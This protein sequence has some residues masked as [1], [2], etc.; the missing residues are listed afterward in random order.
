M[1]KGIRRT[2]AA[3]CAALL[4]ACIGCGTPRQ[5]TKTYYTYFDTVTTLIGFGSEKDFSA[6]CAIVEET[7]EKYHRASD[8][9]HEYGG[10][11]NAMTLNLRAGQGRVE[12]PAELTELLLFGKEV[13]SLTEGS[14]NVAMG[15]VLSL[16]HECRETAL[17]GGEALLPDPEA[18]AEAG[19]HCAIESLLLDPEAGTAELLDGAASVDLGAVAKGYACRKALEALEAA[20]LTGFALSAGGNVCT[21]GT[22]P[23]G[24]AWVAGIDDPRG[25][26]AEGFLLRAAMTPK[27]G[28]VLSLVTSGSYQRY[29][30]VGGVRY[31][32]IISPETLSPRNEYLSV[33]ILCA[34][35]ALADALSTAVF[36]MPWERGI[37]YV[38]QME[39]VE[40]CWVMADGTVRQSGGMGEYILP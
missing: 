5:R 26:S 16:W 38:N 36:N 29:Y 30:E 9:Y 7:L 40:A 12:I 21:L 22:K 13:Y 25:E 2:A 19:K 28:S 20:G 33:S 6:G 39:G 18:L 32:H 35:S 1:K 37:D 31:H 23:G 4:L 24:E 17:D 27:T 10:V 3:V 15:A 14:C 8:I 11:N 34:D